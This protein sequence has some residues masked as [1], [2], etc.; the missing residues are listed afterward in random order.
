[1]KGSI[2]SFF[3][4]I[5]HAVS[6]NVI[7]LFISVVLTLLLPKILG[8]EAYSY[9][10]LYLFY[11]MYL[12]YSSLGWCEGLYLKYGGKSYDELEPR[13]IAGQFWALT[14]YQIVFCGVMTL[15]VMLVVS[16]E[17]K[18]LILP[19]ALM[20]AFFEI[21]RYGLQMIL[22]ATNRIKMY[23]RVA[24]LERILFFV[25]VVGCLVAGARDFRFFI[26][27]EICARILSLGYVLVKCRD[28][29]FVRLPAVKTILAQAKS[30]INTGYKLLCA[31]LASQLVIGIVRFAI[32]QQWGTVVFGKV[33]LTLS[34]SNMVITTIAAISIV[35]FPMLKRMD[36]GKLPQLYGVIRTT[37]TY[38]VLFLHIFYIPMYLLLSAWLPAYSG[39]L[40]YLA[41]LL[42]VCVFEARSFILTDTYFKA[43]NRPDLLLY[44]GLS[45]VVLSI[46]F[47]A[48]SVYV[49]KSLDMAIISIVILVAF[50]NILAENLLKRYISA[51]AWRNIIL[52]L[53][54]VAI[55]ITS[56][57]LIKG[58]AATAIYALS[59]VIYSIIIRDNLKN[60][61]R[62]I[63]GFS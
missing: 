22:Q 9:W 38:P 31:Y 28:I 1:M 46:G 12:V 34:I 21:L 37:V 63:K 41:V 33:S 7:R 17:Y 40:K 36:S 30:L 4:N 56:S 8:V 49:L 52:E 23:A 14:V 10:Q 44:A 19:L 2:R 45:T 55:F 6:V 43:Y 62:R 60:T 51:V 26:G 42:P 11:L 35:L 58:W 27:A 29:V 59:F 5:L 47:S 32:E 54:L 16:D 3:T 61:Y 15:I 48:I 24:G 18:R 53:L 13:D 25:F 39:S 20:S 50:K 57:W